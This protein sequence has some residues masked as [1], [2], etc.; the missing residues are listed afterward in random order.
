MK[1]HLQARNQEGFLQKIEEQIQVLKIFKKVKF[2]KIKKKK[3]KEI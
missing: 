2:Y 1:I 3:N